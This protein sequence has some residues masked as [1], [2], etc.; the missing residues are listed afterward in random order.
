MK[1][2]NDVELENII[3]D[4][5]NSKMISNPLMVFGNSNQ[6]ARIQIVKKIFGDVNFWKITSKDDNPRSTI[7]YCLYDVYLGD[8][9]SND[10]LQNCI[11]IVKRINRPMFCFFDSS[12]I[13][14]V[15]T[16]ILSK[17]DIFEYTK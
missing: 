13:K 15:P 4:Y 1:K 11:N 7:P 12:T 16:E 6:D 9:Y 2:V 8:A 10:I 17:L 3:R 14:F 5:V